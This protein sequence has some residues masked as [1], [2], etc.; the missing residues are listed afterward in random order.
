MVFSSDESDDSDSEV[1]DNDESNDDTDD[2][3]GDEDEDGTN[4]DVGKGKH[5][6]YQEK[7]G[8]EKTLQS[9]EEGACGVGEDQLAG[10]SLDDEKLLSN[11][12]NFDIS[13]EDSLLEITKRTELVQLED[14]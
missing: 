2:D 4:E 5:G 11:E 6:K 10:R 7:S 13:T 8:D 14:R 9:E 3:N 1:S 12:K